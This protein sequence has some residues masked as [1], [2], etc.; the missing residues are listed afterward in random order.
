MSTKNS[1]LLKFQSS[2]VPEKKKGAVGVRGIKLT[3]NDSVDAVYLYE[4]GVETKITYRDKELTL[5]RLKMSKR[6]TAGTKQR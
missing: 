3:K 1:I 2:E 5:N 4:D 6:D